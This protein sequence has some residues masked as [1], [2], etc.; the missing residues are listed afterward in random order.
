MG[1]CESN[2]NITNIKTIN[3]SSEQIEKALFQMENCVCKIKLKNGLIGT[4]FFCKIPFYKNYIPVLITCNHVLDKDSI[5]IGKEINYSI[6]NELINNSIKINKEIKTYTD[7]KKDI[8]IIEIKP[9]NENI[10]FLEIDQINYNLYKNNKLEN[11]FKCKA[12]YIIHY[13]NG[14]RVKYSI[15]KIKNI[16]NNNINHFCQ[17]KEGSSGSPIINISNFKVIG[18]HKGARYNRHYNIGS[19]IFPAL[20]EFESKYNNKI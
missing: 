10:S 18:V 14:N 15:G 9:K 17:T 4:G 20:E 12:I 7:K 13:E 3:V 5:S 8:T 6:N 11:K 2:N 16:K 19:L 1:V